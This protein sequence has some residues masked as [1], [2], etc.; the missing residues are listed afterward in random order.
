[1]ADALL[2]RLRP[3]APDAPASG[4]PVAAPFRDIWQHDETGRIV[5][6]PPGSD[7]PGPRY[8]LVATTN[9]GVK[10][11]AAPSPAATPAAYVPKVGDVVSFG[12]LDRSHARENRYVVQRVL[13]GEVARM[14]GV[15]GAGKDV[16]YREYEILGGTLNCN[17]V[18]RATSSE[19]A[20]AGLPVEESAVDRVA[21]AKA[22]HVAWWGEQTPAKPWELLHTHGHADWLRA[23]DAAIAFLNGGSK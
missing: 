4:A 18:R 5:E 20:A 7:S 11:L 16:Q 12:P 3:S 21:L 19:R 22:M 23:A 2:S 14:R 10:P 8:R 6:L 15:E 17:F 13:N 9:A 1:M